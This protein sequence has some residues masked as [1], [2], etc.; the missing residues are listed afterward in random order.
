MTEEEG[1][2]FLSD[3]SNINDLDDYRPGK[4]AL[5]ELNI[6]SPLKDLG[7]TKNDIRAISKVLGLPTWNRQSFACLASRFPYGSQIIPDLL[8]KTWKAESILRN[9]GIKY[10]RVRNHGDIARIELDMKGMDLI[11]DKSIRDKVVNHIISIGYK[12]VTMDLQGY[13]TGSMNKALKKN[14]NI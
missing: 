7:F 12:Y 13:R 4:R 1:I 8:E 3:G 6:K 14:K 10:Y 9:L 11:M 2:K 5:D